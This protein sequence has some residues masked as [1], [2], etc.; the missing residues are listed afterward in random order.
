MKPVVVLAMHGSPPNDFPR[1][2]LTEFFGLHAQM[3]H[4]SGNT[5]KGLEK[6]Y[7]ELNAKLRSWPRTAEND[8]FYA[9]SQKMASELERTSAYKVIVGYNEFCSPS[10]D[11]AI[12]EAVSR[13]PDK[14]IVI[15]PMMTR[16]GEHSESD[17]QNAIKL[18][19]MRHP[20]I[21]IIYAWPFE[22]SEVANFLA[23]QVNRFV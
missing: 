10:L 9:G 2:E 1:D 14:V 5:R 22:L 19:R 6:R 8:P 17:I 18:S 3:E 13:K 4:T 16:G 11:E 12:E 21:E 20:E 15:T 23:S 7:S